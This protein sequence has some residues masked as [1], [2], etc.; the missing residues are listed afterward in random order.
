MLIKLGLE[1]R[2]IL[3]PLIVE[4]GEGRREKGKVLRFWRWHVQRYYRLG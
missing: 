1:T 2:T 4:K 3:A